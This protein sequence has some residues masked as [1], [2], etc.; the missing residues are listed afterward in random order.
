MMALVAL[1]GAIMVLVAPAHTVRA[2]DGDQTYTQNF[3]NDTMTLSGKSVTTS[4]NF[5]KEDYWD[6]H[7][8]QF[9]FS[10]QV[11]QLS[12]RQ[13]SDI[14]LSLNGV[15]FYSFRPDKTSGLQS[16][17]VDLPLDLL[18]G[19]NVLTINGQII[20]QAG[21]TSDLVT[22]PANWLT[23]SSGANV[24]F[25]YH[26]NELVRTSIPSTPTLLGWIP[27]LI[28]GVPS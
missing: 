23:L 1:I 27:S 3:Q 2:D 21:Q 7:K 13:T 5:T 9:N 28:G 10:F 14:T 17:T 4:L 24:N 20:N 15:K 18:R 26:L 16:K 8:A 6:I 25:T 22:T 11:S 19:S 12:N